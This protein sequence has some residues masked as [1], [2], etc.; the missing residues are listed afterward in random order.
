MRSST[1]PVYLIL[2]EE[3]VG[4]EP[5]V[6]DTDVLKDITNNNIGIDTTKH[7]DKEAPAGPSGVPPPQAGLWKV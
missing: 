6:H 2:K 7:N 5:F 4:Q 1:R 3:M